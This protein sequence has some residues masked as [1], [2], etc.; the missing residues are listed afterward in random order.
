MENNKIIDL[1]SHSVYSDGELTPIELLNL[2][3]E[4]NIGIYAITDHDVLG[5]IKDLRENHQKEI[6]ESGIKII[7][8]IELT[9]KVDKGIMHILGYNIDIYNKELNDKLEELNTNSIYSIISYLNDLRINYNISFKQQDIAELFNKIGNIG[10]PHIAKLLIKYGYVN[11]VK[12]AFD[13]YLI[14]VYNRQRK[15]NK[16]ISSKECIELIKNAGGFAI[17]AHPYSLELSD[18]ELLENIKELISYGL[19]R[20]EV[21]HSNNSEENRKY[22]MQ[23]VKD[24]NLLYSAGSDFHGIHVKPDIELGHG[25]NNNLNIKDVSLIKKISKL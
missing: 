8:G 10:R 14:D 4:N 19:D 13:K 20:I 3:K 12:E 11:S 17:L 24:N 15:N 23:I 2:A 21:Y 5:G 22:Y 1:H 6:N 9:A 16:K 25:I 18:E 7:N